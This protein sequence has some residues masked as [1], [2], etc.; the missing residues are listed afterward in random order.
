MNDGISGFMGGKELLNDDRFVVFS[1]I[2]ESVVDPLTAAAYLCRETSTAQWKR[3]DVDED[4]RSRHAA[5]IAHLETFETNDHSKFNNNSAHEKYFL[6]SVKIAHPRVNIGTGIPNLLTVALGE[7]AFFSHGITSIKLMDVDFP[8]TYLEEIE[9]PLFGADGI[10]DILKV[11][12]RPLFL[13]VVK[14][15]IGLDSKSFADL[16]FEAWVGG[17]DAAKDDEMLADPEYSPFDVRMRHVANA[18]RSA[19]N[20]SGDKKIFIANVTDDI[21]PMLA[22]CEI[23][24]K[25][26]LGAVMVNS[27]AV[28]LATITFLRDKFDIPIVGHFDCIA[29]MSMHPYFGVASNVMT[30]L[31]RISGCDLIIMPGFGERMKTSEQEV[32]LNVHECVNELYNIR[33]AL[34]APGGS[35]W[36]GTLPNIYE[37][38]GNA[39][40]AIVPGRGVFAHPDGPKSGAASLKQAWDAIS[41]GV[42]IDE[43]ARD[44]EELK[45]A[46]RFFDK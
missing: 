27:M 13:G 11:Y 38:V 45:T 20:A 34:P 6:S 8:K 23:A 10:R 30:K 24:V 16:A 1:Y 7:G 4:F 18:L 33:P 37:K 14:P 17:L 21:E 46:V 25:N 41:L 35:D 42:S 43:Y 29:P 15:N 12:D 36:A 39:D 31:Q 44:H 28:G 19:E 22:H 40:F 32:L 26:E 9:G 2:F 3:S 5:K